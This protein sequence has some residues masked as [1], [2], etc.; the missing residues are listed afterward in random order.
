MRGLIPIQKY[1]QRNRIVKKFI[2]SLNSSTSG[3]IGF[4]TIERTFGFIVFTVT[5]I[6]LIMGMELAATQVTT[7]TA[8]LYGVQILFMYRLSISIQHLLRLIINC[9]GLM[10][11]TERTFKIAELPSEK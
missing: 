9:E 10:I 1:G 6:I 11:S 3:N 7:K 5:I 2:D 4:V 8:A